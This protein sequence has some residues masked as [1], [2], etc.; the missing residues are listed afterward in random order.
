MTALQSLNVVEFAGIGP[1]PFAAMMLADMGAQVVRVD[2]AGRIDRQLNSPVDP[3]LRSRKSIAID[4]KTDGGKDLALRLIESSDVLVEGFRPGVMER[5]G[6][7]PKVCFE[8]NSSL[9]YG[10][11]TGWGQE[12]PLADRAGHDITYLAL[13][14]ALH[15]VGFADRPPPPP[16]NYVA[17][18][19]GGGML[20]ATG[21]LAALY[22]RSTSG[23]GQVVDA[24]MVDGAA[25]QTAMLHGLMA[26]GLWRDERESNFL[27]G[28]APFYRT[29]RTSDDKYIA[30]GALEPQFYAQ[31][32]E[33]VELD[34]A[35]WPQNDTGRWAELARQLGAI[36]GSRTRA[37]WEARFCGTDACVAPV[38]SLAEAG[39]HPH[40]QARSAFTK[41]GGVVQPA[42]SPRFSRTST[43]PPTPPRTPGADTDEVLTNL[44]MNATEIDGLR[45]AGT[46]S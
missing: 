40:A 27:D 9:I 16:I 11:V 23:N 15:P 10:R 32:L 24:A 41:I 8:R 39:D 14:G 28:A 6:L 22:E 12:G 43:H 17:D 26:A 7:S 5:L 13:S 30:V 31:L 33:G 29:Y 1:G 36:F 18:F 44:G 4:L 2:R 35:H 20:L 38:L 21:I 3:L 19:G 25:A 46:I 45:N 42:P 37:E 34:P